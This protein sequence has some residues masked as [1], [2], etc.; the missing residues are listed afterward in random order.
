MVNVKDEE[1]KLPLHHAAIRNAKYE[2]IEA[3]IKANRN[4]IFV[5]DGSDKTA[6]QL[7]NQVRKVSK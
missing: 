6:L 2:L 1:G 7:A 4:T 3:L 5:K